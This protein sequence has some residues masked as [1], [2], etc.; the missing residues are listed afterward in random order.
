MHKIPR[1]LDLT[2]GGFL[3]CHIN[4]SYKVGR[5]PGMRGSPDPLYPYRMHSMQPDDRFG[6][7][8]RCAYKQE[9]EALSTL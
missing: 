4:I 1:L 9:Y 3:L 8:V 5:K 6:L 7:Q 2:I